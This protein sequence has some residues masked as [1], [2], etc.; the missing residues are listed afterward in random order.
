MRN[1]EESKKPNTSRVSERTTMTEPDLTTITYSR[2]NVND[3]SSGSRMLLEAAEG[4]NEVNPKQH[5]VDGF[6]DNLLAQMGAG[7]DYCSPHDEC[8]GFHDPRIFPSA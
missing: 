1:S 8:M 5:L 4:P 6:V 7:R 3:D 2:R